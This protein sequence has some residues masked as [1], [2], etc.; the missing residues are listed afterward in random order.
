MVHSVYNAVYL[1]QL[2]TQNLVERLAS[3]YN[4]SS[5]Q[6]VQIFV[7]GPSGIRVVVTDEVCLFSTLFIVNIFLFVYKLL[8]KFKGVSWV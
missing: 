1:D 8:D 7:E 6:V 4:V 2:T 5:S 3:F